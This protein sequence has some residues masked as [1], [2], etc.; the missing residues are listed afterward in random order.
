MLTLLIL[1][2]SVWVVTQVVQFDPSVLLLSAGQLDWETRRF[3]LLA[4]S[5]PGW[6]AE[7]K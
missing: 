5:H 1:T 7:Y 6:H 2:L 3:K 4:S